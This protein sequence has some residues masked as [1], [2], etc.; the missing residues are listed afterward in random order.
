MRIK[1][2]ISNNKAV[3]KALKTKG[4][5]VESMLEEEIFESTY[6]IQTMAIERVPRKFSVLA[7]SITAEVQGLEG[8]VSTPVYY[9]PY[10]EFGTG[11]L[12]DVP[13][14]LESYALQFKGKGLTQVN[15]P[16]RPFLFNS[17]FYQVKV[18]EEETKKRLNAII[19]N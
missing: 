18:L 2:D 19:N 1:I 12:V 14:G 9:A 6:A 7:N 5:R 11:G 4:A 15:L 16:P 10:V 13:E 17:F 3:L 8:Q